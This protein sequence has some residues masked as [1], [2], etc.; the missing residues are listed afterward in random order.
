MFNSKGPHNRQSRGL[1]HSSWSS[2]RRLESSAA[3][4]S[5]L[6]TRGGRRIGVAL[7]KCDTARRWENEPTKVKE[8]HGNQTEWRKHERRSGRR[9]TKRRHADSHKVA[10]VRAW[11]SNLRSAGRV[12][13]TL[14]SLY[15]S[16]PNISFLFFLFCFC[17]TDDVSLTNPFSYEF[18][19]VI[20]ISYRTIVIWL[21]K[22]N[23]FFFF[24]FLPCSL[25]V[26]ICYF[27][28]GCIVRSVVW[29]LSHF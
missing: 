23:R 13:I 22:R 2:T 16:F 26:F 27:S 21:S 11:M 7:W 12:L 25:Y 28:V 24:F 10:N 4:W 29:F 1:I 15:V 8:Q 17:F 14:F 5:A 19:G 18:F 3:P 9:L 6:C 20:R